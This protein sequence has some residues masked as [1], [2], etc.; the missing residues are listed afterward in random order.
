[1]TG[2]RRRDKEIT[3]TAEIKA[4][5]KSAKY[6]TL[7]MCA[8]NEPY[9]ATVSHG[10]DEK[11]GCIY[12]HCA[13]EGKKV[14]ILTENN[15]VWGQALLDRGFVQGSCDHLYA[16]A[17]FKGKVTFVNDYAEK[18]YALEVMIRALDCDPEPL[19]EKQLQ[20]T[21]IQ[22]IAIGRIDIGFVSGKKADKVIISQ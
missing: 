4:I 5:L 1:M 10:Y 3:D 15:N 22:K 2:M 13:P 20:Q 16:T 7:A 6:V 19:I 9:L 14:S 8:K 18:E 17:Q 12:F 21:S 11:H